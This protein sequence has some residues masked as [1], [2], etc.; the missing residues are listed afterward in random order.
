MFQL[1]KFKKSAKVITSVKQSN[2]NK[3]K[4]WKMRKGTQYTLFA[5]LSQQY[6]II[7]IEKKLS[8]V[9]TLMNDGKKIKLTPVQ[10]INVTKKIDSHIWLYS[11]KKKSS[12]TTQISKPS[13]NETNAIVSGFED[14]EH[15]LKEQNCSELL[16][17]TRSCLEAIRTLYKEDI[18]YIHGLV[19]DLNLHELQEI[20]EA[21]GFYKNDKTKSLRK[22]VLN[23]LML[24]PEKTKILKL[25]ILE[26]YN[27]R[28]QKN[29]QLQQPSQVIQQSRL[30]IYNHVETSSPAIQFENLPFFKIIK[31]LLKPMYLKNDSARLFLEP[32][33]LSDN[34]RRSVVESWSIDRQ[35]YKIQIILIFQQVG[36]NENVTKHLPYD[37]AVSVNGHECGLPTLN[38]P[39]NSEQI[40]WQNNT[41][42]D[43]TQHTDLK[44][45]FQ[46][47]LKITWS[48]EPHKYMASVYV[49]QKLTSAD[50]FA[51]LEKRPKRISDK[52]KL[53]IKESMKNDGDMIVDSLFFSVEDPLTK[54]RMKFPARGVD[55]MH[56]QCFDAL[57]FLQLN[58]QKETWKCP[59]CKKKIK[60]ENIVID[61]YFLKMVQSEDL[62][63]EC[64]NVI[65]FKDGTWAERKRRSFSENSRT[66]A[67]RYTNNIEIFIPPNSDDADNSNINFDNINNDE[68][69]PK[70]SG[71]VEINN[72]HQ[73]KD[74]SKMVPCVITLD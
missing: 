50:L 3:L 69:I 73:E 14:T 60:F 24:P 7:K 32:F 8:E 34:V 52:T 17:S 72:R 22:H 25:K 43:I 6:Y 53:L 61:D 36:L 70:S 49:A 48:E 47:S 2:W 46:N 54:L 9:I 62:S 4:F 13:I 21:V 19:S 35:E 15:T 59:I 18:D 58:E 38:S 31:T 41:P 45:G 64:A 39:I 10:N 57:Q 37:F 5:N 65:L 33:H 23:L 1:K 26:V 30:S 71:I 51:E 42:I 29:P 67:R 56:L 28:L 66:K 40:P 74:K 20:L 11:I 63:E 55:C 68:K 12:H 44:Y 16:R 27:S